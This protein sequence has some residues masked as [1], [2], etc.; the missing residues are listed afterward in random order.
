MSY[1]DL[2]IKELAAKIKNK[3]VLPSTLAKESLERAK[4]YQPFYNAFVT[5]TEEEALE[6][7]KKLNDIES[8]NPLFG[9]PYSLK[10]NFSTKDILTTASSNILKNYVP[11]YDAEVVSRLKQRNSILI[12]KTVMDELAMGGTSTS[13]HT[14]KVINPY[15]KTLSHMAGGSSGGSAVSVASGIVPFAIGSDT[16]DSVRK[17]ASYCGV[18]GY[19]PTYGLISRYGLFPFAPSMDHVAF[20]TRTVEDSAFVLDSLVGNDPRDM[21]S[22]IKEKEEYAKNLNKNV[23][24]KKVAVVNGIIKSITDKNIRNIFNDSVNK[25]KELGVQ[26]D[27]IDV[28][29][30]LLRAILPVYMVISCA[31]ATSNDANLDGI[32][33]GDRIEGDTVEETII[34]TRTKGFSELIKRRFILGSYVLKRENQEKL[35][36]RAQ[37]IRRI[38]VN[39]VNEILSSYDALY[40]PAAAT[41][42]PKFN[43][44]VEKLE[45]E[46]LIAE[47]HLAIGNFGGFPS[48]TIPCGEC[49]GLPFGVNFTGKVFDD[50]TVLN[51]AQALEEKT[52]L[53]NKIAAKGGN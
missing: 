16:G 24:G 7:A 17:P 15:S 28:D 39:K 53:K 13:G 22:V 46:Y 20:F 14:G 49:D 18:V 19:K 33:F 12:G 10:D 8:D 21:T 44:N 42:A 27:F 52:G 47:N 9:V 36:L 45:D 4:K 48:I 30:D 6:H 26:V 38:I 32:K 2:S 34:N 23:K 5:I 40:L 29:D 35:F 11:L 3:E 41:T 31:E 51:L 50:Q 43:D 1:L 25:L 37:K